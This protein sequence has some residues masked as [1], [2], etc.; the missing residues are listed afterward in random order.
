MQQPNDKSGGL[1]CGVTQPSPVDIR[2]EAP[3]SSL[4]F[5]NTA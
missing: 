3:L 1:S 4:K 2:V 5:K